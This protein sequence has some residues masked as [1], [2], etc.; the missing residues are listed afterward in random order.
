MASSRYLISSQVLASTASS[1]T[2]SS[3]PATFTD[4]CVKISARVDGTGSYGN[5]LDAQFNNDTS[6]L[7][8][9]TWIYGYGSDGPGSNRGSNQSNPYFGSSNSSVQTSN[10]FASIEIYIPSYTASQNKP[11]GVFSVNE[12]NATNNITTWSSA[13]LYRSTSAISSIKLYE[14]GGS[15]FVTGSSF[16][17]YGLKSS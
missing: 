15:N 9:F 5:Y 12:N 4:L 3:I 11:I 7:Y 13:N 14:N 17:L 6:A 8:S 10:T 16:Y 1:V 2:F